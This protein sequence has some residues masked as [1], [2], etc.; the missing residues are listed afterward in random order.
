MPRTCGGLDV[1]E[2]YGLPLLVTG[3]A[4]PFTCIHMQDGNSYTVISTEV[5]SRKFA[6][7]RFS[8]KM[9]KGGKIRDGENK[10]D[11]RE[12]ENIKEK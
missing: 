10:R 11:G 6:Y 1:P 4:L 9:Q 8:I 7:V 3:I 2:R 12:K 5:L